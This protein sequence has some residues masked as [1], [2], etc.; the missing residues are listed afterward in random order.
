[1]A[2]NCEAWIKRSLKS[3]QSQ[4]YANFRCVV[5]DDVS[6]DQTY[7]YAR[8]A[9]K[10]DE[11][12]TVIRN[13]DRKYQLANAIEATRLAAQ[14]PQ[15][16]IVIVDGDDWLKHERVFERIAEIYSDPK[17]W[18]T[19]G[20]YELLKRNWREVLRRKDR[21]GTQRYPKAVEDS[22][23]YRYHPFMAGHLRTYRKFLFDAVRDEDLRDE[24]GGY[25]WAAGDAALGYPML[26]MAT[27]SHIRY[28]DE[29][30]YVY[31]NDHPFSD[32][33]PQTR[34]RKLLVKLRI[35][36]RPRYIPLVPSSGVGGR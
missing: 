23:L 21:R 13:T 6:P 4:T 27:A 16:V 3:I 28:V 34:E 1:V 29:I 15:D 8:E 2:W 12:F 11:R 17:V 24:D 14:D 33:R 36:S 9:V 10:G 19:Y 18:L 26:E 25:Y 35:A 31:N 32:N 5:I 22:G 30:L 20:N 7:E